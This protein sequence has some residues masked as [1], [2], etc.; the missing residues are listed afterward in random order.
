MSDEPKTEKF[1]FTQKKM[2]TILREGED[3]KR[4]DLVPITVYGDN[5]DISRLVHELIAAA[6]PNHWYGEVKVPPG[7]TVNTKMYSKIMMSEP[8]WQLTQK[9][10]DKYGFPAV[11]PGT[12]IVNPEGAW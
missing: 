5:P 3:I 6:P 7:A 8:C 9:L 12:P 11:P 2:L 1:G 10:I 4:S